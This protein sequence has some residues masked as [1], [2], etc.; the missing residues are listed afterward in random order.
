MRAFPW[1]AVAVLGFG[2]AGALAD[3]STRPAADKTTDE[4]AR[5]A[6]LKRHAAALR[7]IDPGDE[8]F[9][10]L[11]PLRKAIGDARIVQLGEQTH[12]DG[13]TFHAKTRL[14]KFL[15][16]KCGFDVLA[17]ESGLYDCRKAWELL[18]AGEM[19]PRQALAQGVFGI[20]MGSEQMQPL[21]EYL[22]KQ[23]K[24]ARPLEVCG[25]DCQFSGP[26]ATRYLPKD[27]EAVLKEIPEDAFSAEQRDAVL[28]G[29]KS[30]TGGN[31]VTNDQLEA[32][33]DGRTMV[34]NVKPGAKLPC[35][36][37]AFWRQFFEG[38]VVLAEMQPFIKEKPPKMQEY[39]NRRDPQM[40][41]NLIW[42]AREMYPNRKIIV[43]AASMHLL[44]NQETILPPNEPGFPA[45]QRVS[46]YR[47]IKTMG[48][49][50]WKALGKETYNLFFIAA[51]GEF[52]TIR[53]PKPIALKPVPAGSI[54]DLLVKAG[55]DNSFFDL[56]G[57]GPD[58]QWLED[59]LLARPLG[60]ADF[61]ADWTK[62][63]D[64]FVFTRKM[65]P[66]TPV[67]RESAKEGGAPAAANA[68]G[69]KKPFALMVGDA[70]PPITAGQWL[71]GD[72]VTEFKKGHVYVV[73]FWATWCGPCVRN[74]PHLTELQQKYRDRLT[75]IGV[76][77]WEPRPAEVAP[78][79]A[80]M[81]D[82]MAYTVA[83]DKVEGLTTNDEA[84]RSR[85]SVSKGVTSKC[86]LVDSGWADEGIP[87]AFIIDGNGRVA[88]AGDPVDMDGPLAK[89]IGGQWNLAA[90]TE[91]Y[92]A[93]MERVAKV[94][95]LRAAISKALRQK[96]W[97]TVI[98]KC[99]ELLALDPVRSAHIAGCKFQTLLTG[100]KDADRAY[101][102]ARE[103]ITTVARDDASALG[104]IAWVIVHMGGEDGKKHLDV[105]LQA[106]ERAD[107]VAQGKRPGVLATLARIHFLK[108]DAKKALEFQA[109]AVAAAA[110]ED[111][112]KYAKD[113]AEY[114]KAA[115]G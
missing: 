31:G 37:A 110:E 23:A 74:I 115:G 66:S 94:R 58:G 97:P 24:S 83:A 109:K 1:V 63:C 112:G 98:Q 3:E 44:R 68:G 87:V 47:T 25:F 39:G 92:R 93:E 21:A 51:E 29:V 107:A 34:G 78:F 82:K 62:I 81:G 108:G 91:R 105:A 73:E 8:D 65:Y 14:I 52:Q 67:K 16:Q 59:R 4:A 10:D 99:D 101:A 2:V 96:E 111:R 100:M 54:E 86:Y 46:F 26:A 27:L 5:V 35:G 113:L 53:M 72:A 40:A 43:W 104:Q 45:G 114:Q 70:A 84:T 15:H 9:A 30:L 61:E 56:R 41:K 85:E 18:R 69:D 22:G 55:S 60:N 106:A 32:L 75:V 102:F 38:T 57:R 36:D 33:A 6:Y 12:G 89:V 49:D 11:E 28:K 64:G 20:W 95:P 77:V 17:F 80:T 79:V 19:P 88:W 50:V 76:S 90:E 42:L 71:K 13:A 103:A 48:N 7:S